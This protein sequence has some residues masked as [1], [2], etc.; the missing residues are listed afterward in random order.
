VPPRS[1]YGQEER[2][3]GALLL[4]TRP[5]KMNRPT[6]GI[7]FGPRTKQSVRDVYIRALQ[8]SGLLAVEVFPCGGSPVS[9]RRVARRFRGVVLAGGGD[10]H[11]RFY[12]ERDRGCSRFVSK[13]R[14]TYEIE[15]AQELYA[16]GVP[17]LAICRGIQ[18]VCVAFGGTIYQDMRLEILGSLSEP[19]RPKPPALGVWPESPK[20]WLIPEH[21]RRRT[22]KTDRHRIRVA[23]GTMLSRIFDGRRE[24]VVNSR[25][26]QACKTPPGSLRVSARSEDGIIEALE[27][28]GHSF[29]VGV[30]WHPESPPIVGTMR[31]LFDAFSAAVR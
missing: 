20:G 17:L 25:H 12:G 16:R 26:H 31:P 13:E 14:D 30:Q 9:V 18:I 19:P 11:P 15:L 6:V 24:L 2:Y 28:P 21:S 8:S 23:R 10:I 27:D 4:T 3:C 5:S 22:R 29:L 1:T 7:S